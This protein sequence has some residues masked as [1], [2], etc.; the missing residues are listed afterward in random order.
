MA[1]RG[2]LAE[3]AGRRAPV[4]GGGVISSRRCAP[5]TQTPCEARDT[6]GGMTLGPCPAVGAEEACRNREARAHPPCPTSDHVRADVGALGQCCLACPPGPEQTTSSD[7]SC[8]R[9][10]DLFLRHRGSCGSEP[11]HPLARASRSS[12]SHRASTLVAASAIG[13]QLAQCARASPA[14]PGWTRSSGIVRWLLA[15]RSQSLPAIRN[16]QVALAAGPVAGLRL[17]D[18]RR[19]PT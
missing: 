6:A 5:C 9:V 16:Y 7:R 14:Q 1:T 2:A 4:L 12:P 17:N 13:R 3:H 10:P 18:M 15:A 8:R 19:V 11:R